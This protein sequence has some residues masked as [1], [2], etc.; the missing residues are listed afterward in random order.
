MG[1]SPEQFPTS[2]HNYYNRL[3]LKIYFKKFSIESRPSGRRRYALTF[4]MECVHVLN[5]FVAAS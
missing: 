3:R 5:C 4:F 1:T 2:H